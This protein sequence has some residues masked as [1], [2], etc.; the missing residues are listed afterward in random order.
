MFSV[1][2]VCTEL[3]PTGSKCN[4]SNEDVTCV[5]SLTCIDLHPHTLPF[6]TLQHHRDGHHEIRTG[7]S[8]HSFNSGCSA[9]NNNTNKCYVFTDAKYTIYINNFWTKL[10][11]SYADSQHKIIA[12]GS[13][14]QKPS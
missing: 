3:T 11:D 1:I 5:I 9:T 12:T 8:L 10:V 4:S 6:H 13:I 2:S 7:P 14:T